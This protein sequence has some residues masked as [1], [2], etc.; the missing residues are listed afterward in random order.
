LFQC[1]NRFAFNHAGNLFWV[2][3]ANQLANWLDKDVPCYAIAIISELNS[4][5]N[6]SPRMELQSSGIVILDGFNV[7]KPCRQSCSRKCSKIVGELAN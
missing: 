4:Y 6:E 3:A 7:K 2:N 5:S 1:I